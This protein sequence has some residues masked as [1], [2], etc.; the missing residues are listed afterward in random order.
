MKLTN[1]IAAGTLLVAMAFAMPANA[2]NG[3]KKEEDKKAKDKADRNRAEKNGHPKQAVKDEKKVQH[4]NK[5][6]KKDEKK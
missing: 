1:V 4:D 6:I 5:E 2:Q 3:V